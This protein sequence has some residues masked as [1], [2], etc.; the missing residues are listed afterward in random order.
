VCLQITL[1]ILKIKPP[2]PPPPRRPGG[3][4][5]IRGGGCAGLGGVPLADARMLVLEVLLDVLEFDELI[6]DGI[7]RQTTWTVDL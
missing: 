2:P 4:V 5:E 3:A 7:D 6:H 1:P